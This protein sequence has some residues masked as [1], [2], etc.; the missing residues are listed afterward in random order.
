MYKG[1]K[2]GLKNCE[3][4]VTSGKGHYIFEFGDGIFID[5]SIGGDWTSIINHSRK[6]NVVAISDPITK[7]IQLYTSRRIEKGEQLF[8]NYGEDWFKDNNIREL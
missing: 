6:F 3:D 8:L 7:T 4:R 2:I 5:G 1:E